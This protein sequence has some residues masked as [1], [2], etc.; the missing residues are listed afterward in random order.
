MTYV[1]QSVDTDKYIQLSDN[2]LKAGWS[3]DGNCSFIRNNI[4]E[5]LIR[6]TFYSVTMKLAIPSNI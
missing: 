6:K 4:Y 1:R 5:F 3:L 2:D